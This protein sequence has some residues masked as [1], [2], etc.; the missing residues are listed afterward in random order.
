MST[1]SVDISYDLVDGI[2]DVLKGNVNYGGAVIPVYKSMPKTP[3]SVYVLIGEVLGSEDG[4]KDG[5]L[6]FGTVQVII[7]D[8]SAHCADR[9][10]SQGILG[11]VRALLKTTKSKTFTCGSR[12]LVVFSHESMV[13]VTEYADNAIIRNR[14][15][16]IYNYILE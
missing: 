14:L 9:K 11:A 12:T 2:Y 7:V 4:T 6:Y 5:F 3:A 13:P 10:Q 1:A 15:I 8:E 16:D